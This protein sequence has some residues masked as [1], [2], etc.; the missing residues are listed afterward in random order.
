MAQTLTE[1][2]YY[3]CWECDFESDGPDMVVHKADSGHRAVGCLGARQLSAAPPV[4]S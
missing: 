4:R 2:Q 1:T 3:V